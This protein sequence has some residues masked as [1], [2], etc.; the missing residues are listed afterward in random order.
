MAEVVEYVVRIKGLNNMSNDDDSNG[1]NPNT[2]A[3]SSGL[4]FLQK[5]MH[6]IQ[7][8]I[9]TLQ[10]KNEVGYVIGGIANGVVNNVSS[11]ASMNINRYFRLSEDYKGQ[12][13]LNNIMTNVKRAQS[14]GLSI[15]AG[16]LAGAKFGPI[17]AVGGMIISGTSNAVNQVIQYQNL[18]ANYKQS[19]NATRTETVFNANRAGL[20]D[21]GKGTEN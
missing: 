13:N 6:P 20:Y 15:A 4:S 19:L 21:G 18:V 17:G 10:G 7:N 14:F 5:T 1:T 8:S 2:T 16:G 9:K 11:Y 3:L 12:N